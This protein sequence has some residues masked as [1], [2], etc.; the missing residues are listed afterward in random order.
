MIHLYLEKLKNLLRTI[1]DL[2]VHFPEIACEKGASGLWSKKEILGH[3]IDCANHLQHQLIRCQFE[4]EPEIVFDPRNW[5]KHNQYEQFEFNHL[6]RF[7]L[8]Y[9]QHLLQLILLI[10]DEQLTLHVI[11]HPDKT[12]SLEQLI[13]EY[14]DYIE[15]QCLV[16]IS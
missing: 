16:L 11:V 2:L 8:I 13:T 1:P 15:K 4:A 10:P 3:L 12:L 9:N 7:W 14:I 6:T 5:V